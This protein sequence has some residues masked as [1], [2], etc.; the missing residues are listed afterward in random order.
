MSVP[1]IELPPIDR[2]IARAVQARSDTQTKPPGSLGRLESL[3]AQIAAIQNTSNPRAERALIAVFAADHGI[4]AQGVSAW[5]SEVTAQ[6]VR[7][8][9]AGGAAVNV[10]CATNGI[11]LQVVDAGVAAELGDLTGIVHNKI[12]H[13]TADFTSAPAMSERQCR[14]ALAAGIALAQGHA[15]RGVE[16]LGVGDMGIGNTSASALL[17]SMI[18]DIPVAHCVGT[19]AGLDGA[20]LAHKTAILE[21]A[22]QR[23]S[24]ALDGHRPCSPQ[25]AFEVL[26]QGGGFEIAMMAGA[27]LGA[28]SARV[29]VLVDG[30]IAGSA[31]LV[32]WRM[33]PRLREFCIFAH[34]SAEHG[35]LRMLEQ[36]QVEPLL[37][38][39]LRL[40]EGTGAALAIPL[41]RCA[42]ALLRD[43][44]SFDSAGVSTSQSADVNAPATARANFR[45]GDQPGDDSGG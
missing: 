5:P 34:R 30:F 45:G 8:F 12:A 19:G 21:R 11:E 23:V 31:F 18:L 28:A 16:L 2:A 15:A 25:G 43:M 44:S 24:D 40:G 7:N 6:M 42:V 41:L 27:M 32:A 37:D 17:M 10:L 38:L 26:R 20:G 9:A 3:A 22:T 35:H 13:G 33:H 14:D 1:I 39:N 29:P 4:T 36:L